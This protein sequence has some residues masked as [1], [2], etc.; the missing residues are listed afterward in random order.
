MQTK[1]AKIARVA[2]NY[3]LATCVILLL[4]GNLVSAIA[5]TTNIITLTNSDAVATSSFNSAG[6]WDS[7]A[8][9][10][11]GNPNFNAYY[12]TNFILRTPADG[13]SYVFA[14]DSL[15][16]DPFSTNIVGLVTNIGTGTLSMK[17]Y[18][19]IAIGNLLLNGGTVVNNGTGGSPDTALLAG[20]I[21]AEVTSTLDGGN[22]NG[23]TGTTLNVLAPIT[24][25]GG[26]NILD[27]GTVDFSATNSYA[28]QTTIGNGTTIGG[29]LKVNSSGALP[30]SVTPG[31]GIGNLRVNFVTNTLAGSTFDLNG[32]NVTA[33][34]LISGSSN[35][36]SSL[37]QVINSAVGTTNTFT[38]GNNNNGAPYTYRGVIKDNAGTGGVLALTVTG[39]SP[40]AIFI[41]DCPVG[42]MTYSGDTTVNGGVLS[43]RVSGNQLPWG[44]GKGNMIV[45]NSGILDLNGHS[46]QIN[47]LSGDGII[48]NL[49]TGTGHCTFNCGSNDV[50]STFSGIIQ[51]SQYFPSLPTDYYIQLVKF[52]AGTLT[53]TGTNTFNGNV[54]IHD[55]A[56]RITYQNGDGVTGGGLGLGSETTP[57]TKAVTI[58]SSLG[59]AGLLLD[60][61]SG[62]PITVDSS[63]SFQTAGTNGAI[64]N[65]AGNNIIN[66]AI[67]LRTGGGTTVR[68]DGGTLTLAGNIN[69]VSNTTSRTL[70]LSGAANG[71]LSGVIA[72]GSSAI[73]PTT[74]VLSLTKTGAGTWTLANS[75]TYSDV[76][77]VNGGT[78]L[79]SGSLSAV[80]A[81]TVAAGTLG[82]SGTIGGNVTVAGSPAAII[83]PGGGSTLTCG[84]NVTFS[85]GSEAAFDLSSSV[86][87]GNDRIVLNGPNSTLACGSAQ[88]TINSAGNLAA[89][90]Y[91]LFNVTGVSGSISG[92][93]SSTP[94]WLGT[95]PANAANY[96]I[97]TSGQQVLL[98]YAAAAPPQPHITSIKLAGSS[99]ILSGTNGSTSSQSVL[100]TSTN[101][102]LALTNWTPVATN[103]FTSGNF[104][105]TNTL[106]P[107]ARQGFYILKVQ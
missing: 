38:V 95:T 52:G 68:V 43:M 70:T 82:G 96:S 86:S 50:S 84:S 63:I 51:N 10:L 3:R 22:S 56:I 8:A 20:N 94:L 83:H 105:I 4:A 57:P 42:G 36:N 27:K 53:L 21:I 47:G 102:T 85:A 44:P 59:D 45:N 74:N 79:V 75:N 17:G 78:L 9:P 89:A 2:I 24:G 1:L 88:I 60:A 93:F 92:N 55:G 87:S 71:T 23:V 32:F 12:T 106:N 77:T 58:D 107:N 15:S 33:S 76:T 103:T 26:I 34:E 98:H 37:P 41:C 54:S 39:M 35:A 61:T 18:G 80:S 66:G 48:D 97:V 40:N 49:T 73:S 19:T 13:N 11:S 67:S 14:G 104:S 29:Y 90:D 62:V 99:L 72:D 30:L 16:V 100:L 7:G 65:E 31:D 5:Q 81:V 46:P 69:I 25:A 101:V 28:G 6:N 91:V 64:V